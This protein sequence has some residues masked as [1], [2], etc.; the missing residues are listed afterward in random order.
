MSQ[1]N[2]EEQEEAEE[3]SLEEEKEFLLEQPGNQELE[4]NRQHVNPIHS[5]MRSKM[6]LRFAQNMKN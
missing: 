1:V 5:Q 6:R 4:L 3:D 2:S